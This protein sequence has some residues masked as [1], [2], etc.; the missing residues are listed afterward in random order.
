V[1]AM[2]RVAIVGYGYWGPN[3]VR[4]FAEAAGSRVD[5][6]CDARPERLAAVAKRYPAVRTTSDFADILRDREIDAVAIATPVRAHYEMALAALEAGKHVLLEKPMTETADQ[7]QRLIDLAERR[8]RT[9]MVDHTFVYTPTV[10]KL[11]ELVASGQLGEV[12]YYDSLRVNLG[13][14]QH[15]VNV[16]WDLAVHDFS[17]LEYVLDQHPV[18]VSANGISAVPNQPESVAYISLFFAGGTIAHVNVNWLAPVKVRQTLIGG[19]RKM[20]VV[21]ELAPSEKVRVYD[22]GVTLTDDPE[23]IYQL[24]IGYRSGDMWAPQLAT[25]EALLVAAEHFVGC[26][27]SGRRPDTDGAMGL[28]IVE[29]LEAA[30]ASLRRR[31]QPVEIKGTP[32]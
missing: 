10:R 5:A 21:D 18:A 4:N 14:F 28:R 15:D 24:R 2:I 26:I 7:A 17:I 20:I 32:S 27:A 29:L 9:L 11:R 13:L 30:T 25:T 8:R 12:Y 19:S 23:K 1:G 22:K 6:V 16:I 31:G 3:L